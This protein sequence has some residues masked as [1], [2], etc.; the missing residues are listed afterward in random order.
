MK[1]AIIGGTGLLGSEVVRAFSNKRDAFEVTVISRRQ[2]Q[3]QE[4]PGLR[5][6]TVPTYTDEGDG[7]LIKALQGQDVLVSMLGGP[8]APAGKPLSRSR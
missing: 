8:I 1:V 2:S 5:Y 7:G 4:L 6:V 3:G